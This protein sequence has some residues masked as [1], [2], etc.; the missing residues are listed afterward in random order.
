MSERLRTVFMGSPE[1]AVSSLQAV[2]RR[3]ELVAVVTQP[4]RP[5]GR[6]RKLKPPAV[7]VEAA[8]LGVPV[9]QPT[10]VRKGKL[11]ALLEPYAPELIVVTAYGRILGADVLELPKHGCV[12]VHA[13]L[14]PRWRGAAPI[15]RAVLAGD[16][17][18]GVA[19]M[20][21]DIGC[22][23][24]PVYRM[25]ATPIGVE[26]TSGELFERLAVLGGELL[27]EFLLEF[28]SVP[29]PQDQSE[30][31]GEVLHAAK[32]EKSEG[33]V[34]WGRDA[35]Q[36]VNHVRGMDPWPAAFSSHGGAQIKLFAAG[37]S[38]WPRPERAVAAGTVLGVDD[39]GVHVCC[40]DGVVRIGQLQAPGKRRMSAR[41]YAAGH[42]FA[43]H[44]RLGVHG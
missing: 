11:R 35:V 38:R 6:G 39:D 30:L 37:L 5:S 18:T 24:G 40:G 7:K 8:T 20:R 27:D 13:S 44:E 33:Q 4:D 1:F 2:A 43:E 28:P 22:D 16:L 42:P 26:E 34:D 21:M 9:L 12:N 32:L 41:E 23:T 17:Q 36:V 10:K 31:D 14:L 15:Q 29:P 3:C 25:R 19:I